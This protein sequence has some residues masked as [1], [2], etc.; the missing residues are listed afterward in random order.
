[1]RVVVII[2][3]QWPTN[4][5]PQIEGELTPDP[6][7]LNPGDIFIPSKP[8]ASG[9]ARKRSLPTS[10][11]LSRALAREADISSPLGG[12]DIFT[13]RTH[14]IAPSNLNPSALPNFALLEPHIDAI[15]GKP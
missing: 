12:E 13:P 1:M 5:E 9:L 14:H 3:L 2:I 4:P 11:P 15:P 10:H 7:L 6:T 8:P